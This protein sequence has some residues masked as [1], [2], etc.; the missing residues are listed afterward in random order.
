MEKARSRSSLTE[1]VTSEEPRSGEDML[2]GD[3]K[4]GGLNR[5]G[6]LDLRLQ[7]RF[8]REG[9]RR[10]G[11]AASGK[12]VVQRVP[13]PVVASSGVWETTSEPASRQRGGDG[14]GAGVEGAGVREHCDE[15]G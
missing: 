3:E 14:K 12:S 13:S 7:R 10:K 2:L 11:D 8:H 9:L 1:R 15:K 4:G 5:E 6:P